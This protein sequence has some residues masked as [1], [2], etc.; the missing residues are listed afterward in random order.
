MYYYIDLDICFDMILSCCVK[1][2]SPSMGSGHFPKEAYKKAA[3]VNG[4]E[5]VNDIR[6]K[7]QSPPIYNL[8][9]LSSNPNCTKQ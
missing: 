8:K 9:T 5:I 6:Y 4:I 7:A 3:Y 2:K 1:E